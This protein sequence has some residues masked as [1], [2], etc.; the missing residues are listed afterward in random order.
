MVS[1]AVFESWAPCL[2]LHGSPE[3]RAT[4]EPVTA[5]RTQL[6]LL[7]NRHLRQA[8]MDEVPRLE[9]M[10]STTTCSAIWYFGR[11]G[12]SQVASHRPT[13]LCQIN[14]LAQFR[15]PGQSSGILSNPPEFCCQFCCQPLPGSVWR[16]KEKEWPEQRK[17]SD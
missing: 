17:Y 15:C 1:E 9:S 7:K 16:S 4:F 13:F 11:F 8:W 6:A 3:E 14:D 10:L 2:R 12:Q 5:S